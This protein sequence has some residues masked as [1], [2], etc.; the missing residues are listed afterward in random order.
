[1][2]EKKVLKWW[3]KRCG[4]TWRLSEKLAPPWDQIGFERTGWINGCGGKVGGVRDGSVGRIISGGE[5]RR[6][7]VGNV[8]AENGM[9]ECET[10]LFRGTYMD[11]SPGEVSPLM[12]RRQAS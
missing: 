2:Y 12:R 6:I 11:I 1:M 3:L 9:S 4:T 10:K 5:S 8:T 7:G